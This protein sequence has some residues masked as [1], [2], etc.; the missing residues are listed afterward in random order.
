M[1]TA[2]LLLITVLSWWLGGVTI[3]SALRRGR[4]PA[5]Q[6]AGVEI[7][8]L[9][10]LVGMGLSSWGAF[11]WDLAGGGGIRRFPLIWTAAL[12]VP[13]AW[14]AGRW[15]R[16]SRGGSIAAPVSPTPVQPAG[17]PSGG[18]SPSL[19]PRD[20]GVGAWVRLAR[21]LVLVIW[22][23]LV[24]QTL[25]TPQRLWDERAI[26]G[27]KAAVLYE[28][29]TVRSPALL[30]PDFVQG[31]P[32]YP[33]LLPLAEAS[34]YSWLGR[35][36]DRWAKLVPPLTGLGLWLTF[37]GVLTRRLGAGPAWLW[38]LLMATTPALTTWEYGFLSA[39]ADAVVGCFH[40]VSVLYL[41]D[42]LTDRT[43]RDGE[44]TSP[45]VPP[46]ATAGL[47]AALAL[48]TKDEGI[49]LGLVDGALLTGLGWLALG[50]NREC[51]SARV[52]RR[53]FGAAAAALV[54]VLLIALPW[55]LHRRQLPLTEEMG[56]FDRLGLEALWGGLAAVPW[57]ARHLVSRMFLEAGT[58]GLHWWGA[59]AA[60][61]LRPRRAGMTAQA[62][63]WLDVLGAL[64]AL[65]VAG[66]LAPIPAEEHIGGSAHRFLL[67]LTPVAVLLIATQCHSDPG[68]ESAAHQE[69]RP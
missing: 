64:A 33:L 65:T 12:A 52:L 1:S 58:W 36:D 34:I 14:I 45:P 42:W 68:T 32:R 11:V 37:A 27:I 19:S 10:L 24:A 57:I 4:V 53:A 44:A 49:A 13:G 31:H 8:G 43:E 25:L 54:P 23:S 39:Q 38:T 35:V 22:A 56:Y 2:A 69:P 26:F 17:S 6:H 29:D 62:L 63:L 66:M 48:W 41:W 21:G 9:S 5:G 7:A 55:F 59:A 60:C 15:W 3:V 30:D 47:M 46:L 40:G 20:G 61:L 18:T 16:S 50:R 51:R 67:Q 28:D